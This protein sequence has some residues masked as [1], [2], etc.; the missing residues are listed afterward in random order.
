MMMA[1][2]LLSYVD[3]QILAV[4][5]PMI[6]ADLKLNAE[7]YAEIVSAFSVA[8]M[9]GNPMWGAILDRIGLRRGMA[10]AVNRHAQIALAGE[11]RRQPAHRRAHLQ[12][13]PRRARSDAA[14]GADRP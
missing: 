3:R 1:C 12:P 10:L 4:L 2:S 8:Y 6:L 14:R 13:R 9:L 5:S 11:P 7:K